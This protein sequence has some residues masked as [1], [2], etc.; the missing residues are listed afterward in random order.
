MKEDLT[1]QLQLKFLE[2]G[3]GDDRIRNV[4]SVGGGSINETFAF[5]HASGKYFLKLND[6]KRFPGMFATEA[7]G[8]QLLAAKGLIVP[9]VVFTGFF[10]NVQY[11]VLDYLT[12]ERE[13]EDFYYALGA[14]LARLH[15]NTRKDF[16]F[17]AANYIGSLPQDNTPCETWNDFFISRRIEPLLRQSVDNGLFPRQYQK[18][19]ERFF[20]LL[21]ELFPRERPALLHG[22]LWS[23]NKMNTAYGPAIFDPAV[24]YGHREADIA[25]TQL[26][27]GFSNTFYE[28]YNDT[29][30]LEKDWEQRVELFNLYPL[31][32]HTIL[33]GASYSQD[34]QLIIKKF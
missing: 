5:E 2:S 8:L 22:D 28:G 23:G 25:M 34:V 13:T 31:L 10:E 26:F 20:S 9:E 1:S 14:G 7:K 16:G 11:L 21:D 24:Y 30:P 32:V 3:K 17:D 12:A 19:F 27:G 4:K 29:L 6:E 18:N 33:F 15:S